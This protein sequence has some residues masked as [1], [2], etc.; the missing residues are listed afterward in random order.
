MDTREKLGDDIM[1][2]IDPKLMDILKVLLKDITTDVMLRIAQD[3]DILVRLQA[4][5]AKPH[6]TLTLFV[7]ITQDEPHREN[8]PLN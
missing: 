6:V 2:L 4:L 3:P 1:G 5:N 7:T 8:N